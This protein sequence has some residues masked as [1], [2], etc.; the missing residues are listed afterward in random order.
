MIFHQ[1]MIAIS[2]GN[3]E[4]KYFFSKNDVIL[5]NFKIIL[6]KKTFYMPAGLGN[7]NFGTLNKHIF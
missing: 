1:I 7:F 6:Q 2:K 3:E 4:R 5:I